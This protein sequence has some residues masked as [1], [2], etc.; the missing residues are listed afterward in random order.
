VSEVT[1]SQW[2]LQWIDMQIH[3]LHIIWNNV[4]GPIF[5]CCW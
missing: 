2:A 1:V 4:F 3:E 5:N